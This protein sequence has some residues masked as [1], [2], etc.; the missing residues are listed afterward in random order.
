MMNILSF[1]IEEWFVYEQYPKGGRSYYKPIIDNYLNS[2]LDLLDKHN[3]KAT[4]FCLGVI[5][6]NDREVIKL[7]HDRGHH[8]GSHSDQHHFITRL[9]PD[10]FREDCRLSKQSLEDLIG[11]EVDS[12]R[13]P[14]FTITPKTSWALEILAEEGFKY[15]SSI[16]PAS[17]SFGGFNLDLTDPVELVH[18][19]YRIKE[20]PI[21]FKEIGGK[22][23]MYS[24]GGYFRFVPSYLINRWMKATDYNMAYFHI[25]DFDAQQKVVMSLRYLKSYYGIKG[26]FSKFEKLLEN[27][28][29]ISLQEAI[30]KVDWEKSKYPF[31]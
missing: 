20:F 11:E 24:G 16:F 10:E 1:D 31:S 7:I 4:F 22:R 2:I 23:L 3:T 9:N 30:Q 15:D 28:H 27:Q 13:A 19:N 8:I 25:R 17:R 5:A 29:F 26:A 12:Y 18:E 14:A 6:R 21:N